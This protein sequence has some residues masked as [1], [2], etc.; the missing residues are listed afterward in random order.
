ADTF[1][2]GFDWLSDRYGRFTARAIRMATIMLV[3]Y[4]GLLA[5]TGWRLMD[6]PTG[7]IPEQDQGIPIG[8]GQMP[9]GAPLDRTNEVLDEVFK[10]AIEQE[11]VH[12]AISIAGLDGT[13]SATSSNAGTIFMRLTDWS[14]RGEELSADALAAS[15]TGKLA[16]LTDQGN[17]F[18]VA[19]P[20]V[21]GLGNGSGFVMMVQDRGGG[22]YRE[23]EATA[24]PLMGA[25]AQE[26]E[27]LSQ[28]FT[29]FNTGT[30]RIR[31]D[32]DRDRAQLLG[33]QPG[34][35]YDALGTYVGST[36]VNDFNFMG[37]TYRVTAQAEPYARDDATD[38]GRLQVRSSTGSMVPV[39]SVASFSNES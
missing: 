12:S 8:V 1:N 33:V 14:E 23:L 11:G 3:I 32:V 27:V 13:T 38:I 36:Y 16:A 20:T 5:L 34:Q 21:S 4:A 6:T 7:L 18:M 2:R 37:R 39:S 19:P 26:P 25:A 10:A 22:T 31:A 17:I 15:L 35:V 29:T 28:V 30:P 9:P 24:G